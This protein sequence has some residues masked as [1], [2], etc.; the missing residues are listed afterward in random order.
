MKTTRS[1]YHRE[2]SASSPQTSRSR[3]RTPVDARAHRR[4]RRRRPHDSNAVDQTVVYNKTFSR[5]ERKT[6]LSLITLILPTKKCFWSRRLAR[7]FGGKKSA[8]SPSSTV[9]DDFPRRTWTLDDGVDE[10]SRCVSDNDT[11]EREIKNKNKW[12]KNFQI[13]FIPFFLLLSH[14]GF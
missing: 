14:L 10:E 11:D 5:L 3:G 2:H 13:F 7:T 1:R 12:M 8:R 9:R 6:T 4:R